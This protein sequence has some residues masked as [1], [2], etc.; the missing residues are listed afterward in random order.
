MIYEE[1]D[2]SLDEAIQLATPEFGSN[3]KRRFTNV[4]VSQ[5][6]R[7]C[8][9][10]CTP[11]KLEDTFIRDGQNRIQLKNIEIADALV[12]R[13]NEIIPNL[14]ERHLRISADWY[15]ITLKGTYQMFNTSQMKLLP[16]ISTGDFV[17][18]IE[19][20]VAHGVVGF[21]TAG[22]ALQATNFDIEYDAENVSVEVEYFN[23]L[24]N[25]KERNCIKDQ[26]IGNTIAKHIR[27]DLYLKLEES[28][29]KNLN[30]VLMDYNLMEIF[31]D[32]AEISNKYRNMVGS[33]ERVT[34][35]FVDKVLAEVNKR[36]RISIN[37]PSIS[38]SGFVAQTGK[39]AH[40]QTLCRRRNFSK[41]INKQNGYV[42]LFGEIEL[43][44][45][46]VTYEY[47]SF[48][49]LHGFLKAEATN[50]RMRLRLTTTTS[51][52]LRAEL[53]FN[54]AHLRVLTF[55]NLELDV[56]G[57]GIFNWIEE[58]IRAVLNNAFKTDVTRNLGDKLRKSFQQFV[59]GSPKKRQ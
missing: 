54:D 44:K 28:L 8:K 52:F 19:D 39:L 42:T 3:L 38:E 45:C 35:T 12:S 25:A 27:N 15:N 56:S 24:K 21:T 43:G 57:M 17:I 18:S 59:Q 23:N 29:R 4:G 22:E 32:N 7:N 34:N 11:T 9:N 47:W 13:M 2:P 48:W 31:N 41:I 14:K 33:S 37:L 58:Q 30:E 1:F 5:S 16:V 51:N 55:G 26:E 46:L 50:N 49:I 53:I 6:M 20:T 40:L 36:N 10:G